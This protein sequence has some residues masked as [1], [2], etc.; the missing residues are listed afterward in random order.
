VK[1]SALQQSGM[2]IAS[3][4]CRAVNDSILGNFCSMAMS[5]TGDPAVDAELR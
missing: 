4:P 2:F 5:P 3:L 1:Q